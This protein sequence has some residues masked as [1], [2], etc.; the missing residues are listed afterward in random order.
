[1]SSPSKFLGQTWGGVYLSR[2][3]S[4]TG[5]LGFL[6]FFSVAENIFS[7]D[8]GDQ[9]DIGDPNGHFLKKFPSS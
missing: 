4:K 8:Y 7:G 6:W 5:Y 2:S 1:L 3:D 9:F